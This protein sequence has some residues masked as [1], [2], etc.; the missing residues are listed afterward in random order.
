MVVEASR[1]SIPEAKTPKTLSER[2]AYANPKHK[3][4]SGPLMQDSANPKAQPKSATATK[5]T[6]KDAKAR[7]GKNAATK[8]TRPQRSKPKTAEE[9]DAEMTDY[10]NA[11]NNA[12][13][14]PAAVSDPNGAAAA[15]AGG[16]D[17]GMDEISV[18][19]LDI[20]V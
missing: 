19:S 5:A 14:A 9:L 10:F 15:L 18:S 13:A 17:T 1:V 7:K 3:T 6:A 4:K 16:D 8:K 2:V 11:G 12:S 20:I